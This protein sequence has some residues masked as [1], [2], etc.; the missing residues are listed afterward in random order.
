MS[1]KI[2]CIIVD[3][4]DSTPYLHPESFNSWDEAEKKVISLA[5]DYI[6]EFSNPDGNVYYSDG[7]M[8]VYSGEF[9]LMNYNIETVSLPE[10]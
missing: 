1:K 5:K 3:E 8:C 9:P 4:T 7:D 2:Y 6:S 10:G